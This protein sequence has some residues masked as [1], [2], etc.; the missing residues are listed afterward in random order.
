MQD[1]PASTPDE[2]RAREAA[3]WTA[4]YRLLRR[5]TI[6]RVGKT[7]LISISYTGANAD[8]SARIVNTYVEAYLADQLEGKYDSTRRANAWLLAA[9]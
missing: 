3:R 6:T 2:A 9:A 8:Q 4:A 7:Y 1:K 5:T